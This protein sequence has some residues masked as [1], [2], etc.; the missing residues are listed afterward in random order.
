MK[1]RGIGA[2]QVQGRLGAAELG[3]L[4]W[5][6]ELERGG[7]GGHGHRF[8]DAAFTFAGAYAALLCPLLVDA[9][10]E[11]GPGLPVAVA[12]ADFLTLLAAHREAWIRE[13][14]SAFADLKGTVRFAA[15][16]LIL[17]L[18]KPG[19]LVTRRAHAP[20]QKEHPLG[21]GRAHQR[22]SLEFLLS[23]LRFCRA[24]SPLLVDFLSETVSFKRGLWYH[25]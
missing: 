21:S 16:R 13:L 6:V 24:L 20:H 22:R 8:L 18:A 7:L 4:G 25:S 10:A 15:L 2:G 19:G 14:P 11:P 23:T 3:C 12:T 5:V 17:R 1:R 9:A